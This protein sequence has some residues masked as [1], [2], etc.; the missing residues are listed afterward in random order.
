MA[1]MHVR[2]VPHIKIQGE[3]SVQQAQ[4]SIDVVNYAHSIVFI[5]YCGLTQIVSTSVNTPCLEY[6]PFV[7]FI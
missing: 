6:T 7:E 3:T 5:K 1:H 4:G 2:H